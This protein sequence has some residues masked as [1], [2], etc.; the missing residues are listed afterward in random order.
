MPASSRLTRLLLLIALAALPARSGAADYSLTPELRAQ[1]LAHV[2]RSLERTLAKVGDSFPIATEQGGW[3]TGDDGWT[4]GYFAGMLWMMYQLTGQERWRQQAEHYTGLLAH[5]RH[6]ADNS[7]VGILFWPSF[8]L[9]YRLTGN[10][11][12]RQVGIDGAR[13]MLRRFNPRGG[14]LQNWGAL[15][16]RELGGCVIIDCLINLDHLCWAARELG[17]PYFAA[18]AASHARRSRQAHLRE[19]GSVCQVAEFDQDNGTVLRRFKKQGYADQSTWSRGQSWAIYGFTRAYANAGDR[20]FLEAAQHA[21]DWFIAH[22]PADRV[23][24]WDF[25]A[26]K[27]PDDARDSSAGSMAAAGL[28]EL[29]R[30][31]RDPIARER[32]HR[33][34]EEIL[35]SLTMNYLTRD[36]ADGVL[37]GGT[38]FYELGRSVDQANIWGDF[39]YL[40]ALLRLD[41][42][43]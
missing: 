26:P 17:D 20:E 8:D 12:Y 11:E 6:D 29:A 36:S 37:T 25:Q 41:G 4:G 9:G 31:V 24:Y 32:Y 21:S 33:A 5:H 16:D 35:A 43:L 34:A 13:A 10:P 23:P 28:I 30:L 38:Y 27:I 14:F 1:G 3:E 7:D 39:Y 2:E 15:G 40:E 22:L 18:C 42:L 19:D